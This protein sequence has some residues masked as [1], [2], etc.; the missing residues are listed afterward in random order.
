[1]PVNVIPNATT[2]RP[3]RAKVV[4]GEPVKGRALSSH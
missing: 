3:R 2:I 1:M 4:V